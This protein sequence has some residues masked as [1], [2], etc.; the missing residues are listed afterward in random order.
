ME[1]MDL[2]GISKTAEMQPN[3]AVYHSKKAA[4]TMDREPA[5]EAVLVSSNSTEWP[6]VALS[7]SSV[8]QGF[9]MM[10]KME[11]EQQRMTHGFV[12]I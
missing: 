3:F 9:C 4:D 6:L 10:L 11:R 7:H 8:I 12:E 5:L 1:I 2:R